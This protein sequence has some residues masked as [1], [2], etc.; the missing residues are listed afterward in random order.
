LP[1]PD[2][3]SSLVGLQLFLVVWKLA[4]LSKISPNRVAHCSP[5]FLAGWCTNWV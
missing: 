1:S 4:Y 3:E 2:F 5:S